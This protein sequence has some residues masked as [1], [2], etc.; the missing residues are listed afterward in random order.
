MA[1]M[2][3]G[4]M[5]GVGNASFAARCISILLLASPAI[6]QIS[7]AFAPRPFTTR[8]TTSNAKTTSNTALHLRVAYQGEPGAYSE[9]STRELLGDNVIAIGKPNFEACFRAVASMEVDYCCLPVENSLGGSIHENYDLMLRYDLTICA[10]H[11]FRVQHCVLAKPGVRLPDGKNDNQDDGETTVA[12]FAISHPQ[13]LAQCD[14]Y[15]RSLG[16]IP[17][18]TYDTAGSAKMIQD[19]DL[20]DRCTPENT[21]AIASDLAGITY[22][23]NCL[24]KGV[25][26]DDSNFTR[27]LLL[28]RKGVLEYLGKDVPSKTSVVFTLPNTAGALYKAL[29]CFSL[30]D[31]DFSKIESR[32]TSAALLNYLKFRK[33]QQ[34]YAEQKDNSKLS[35]DDDLPRFRYCFY[36]DFLDGQLSSNSENA[37]SNLREFTDFVR[38]LGSYPRK[39]Q[40][41]GPVKAAAAEIKIQRVPDDADAAVDVGRDD[42][43]VNDSLRIGLVGFGSFGQVLAARM[44]D[45]NHE[46]SCLDMNDKSEEAAKL[47]VDFHYDAT[48]FFRG[49]DVVVMSVPLI[50]LQEA[51]DSLPIHELRGKLVVDVSPSNDRPKSIL[52]QAFASYPDID[53]LVTNPLLGMVPR[54]EHAT[55]RVHDSSSLW[56]GRQMVYERARVAN[57]PR[58]DRYLEIFER[59]RCE[60][61]EEI[62]GV[63][64]SAVADSQFV[65]HLI[66]RLLDRDLLAPT[67]IASKEYKDLTALS[68]IAATGSLDRFYGMYKYNPRAKNIIRTLRENL[69]SLECE[70]AARGAYL[71]AKE[72]SAKGDR[73]RLLSETR[74]LLQE[75]AKSDFAADTTPVTVSSSS[76]SETIDGSVE[77]EASE[78]IEEAEDTTINDEQDGSMFFLK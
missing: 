73:Q 74:L 16:I 41:V 21:I 6:L 77:M 59:A 25:E 54:E 22:G 29:A 5:I 26:D 71:E 27:F 68:E 31:I 32:P 15:L 10:E 70:L 58:C 50:R 52:L 72:E 33:S 1:E 35:I 19:D 55:H 65:T 14:N 57:V 63:H 2:T 42:A 24:A 13:A 66:G 44:I 49:L 75:L 61:V 23:M 51:V 36:L 17:I 7:D 11:E 78:K 4:K 34:T 3:S 20:P 28:G 38:I 56:E 9:K 45:D 48:N 67:P 8:T 40:L 46:V 60:V 39:S 76:S 62:T 69:A 53:V 18:P 47:G 37:L 30:R 12:R 43:T 64:D